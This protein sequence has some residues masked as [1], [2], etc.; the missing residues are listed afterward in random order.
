LITGTDLLELNGEDLR[1]LPFEKRK[2]KLATVLA[3]T[4]VGIALNEHTEADGATMFRQAR[5]MG[6][7]GIVSKRLRA[8]YRSGPSRDYISDNVLE[9]SESLRLS[10]ARDNRHFSQI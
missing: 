3:R 6:L 8:L 2:A 5:A 7:E 4:N 9:R 1:S 10:P